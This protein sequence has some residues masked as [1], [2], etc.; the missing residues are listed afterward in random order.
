[1]QRQ[2]FPQLA[3]ERSG[4][5]AGEEAG[6][7]G[8]PGEGSQGATQPWQVGLPALQPEIARQGGWQ[9]EAGLLDPGE[10]TS[11]GSNGSGI[12][13]LSGPPSP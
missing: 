12:D 9:Q 13:R 1:M 6:G 2:G 8:D 10:K 3:P 5:G 7:A 11:Q 4:R